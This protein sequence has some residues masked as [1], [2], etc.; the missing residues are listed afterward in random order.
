MLEKKVRIAWIDNVKGIA[1]LLVV[2]GHVIQFMYCPSNF[3]QNPVFRVIYSFHMPLFFILSGCVTKSIIY[4][5]AAN[6]GG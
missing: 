3:D 2:L 1:I 6:G 4:R 5:S